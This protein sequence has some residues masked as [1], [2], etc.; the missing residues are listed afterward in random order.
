M[1]DSVPSDQLAPLNDTGSTISLAELEAR[2]DDFSSVIPLALWYATHHA[3]H[4][5]DSSVTDQPRDV[6]RLCSQEQGKL[7]SRLSRLF[8]NEL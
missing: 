4:F 3:R 2:S 8:S 7:S 6:I 5:Q 1:C